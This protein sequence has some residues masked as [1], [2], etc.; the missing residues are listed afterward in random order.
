[1]KRSLHIM[2]IWGVIPLCI[3]LSAVYFFWDARALGAYGDDSPGYM[4]LAGRLLHHEP[5][6]FVGELSEEALAFFGD[7]KLARWTIPTHHQFINPSGMAASKYPL[8]L[9]LLLYIGARIVDAPEGMSSVQPLSGIGIV[10]GVYVLCMLIFRAERYRLAIALFSAT[11]LTTAPLFFQS[12]LS[13]PMRELPALAALIWA[14]IVALLALRSPSRTWSICGYLFAGILFGAGVAIRETLILIAPAL[15]VLVWSVV[16]QNRERMIAI[17]VGAC[18]LCIALVPLV[19]TSMTISEEKVPFKKRDTD[20][21]VILP[22]EGHLETIGLEN[23]FNNQGKYKIG[24]GSLPTYI[25]RM[26]T[27]LP[28][29][30]FGFFVLY[31]CVALYRKH[32]RTLAFLLLWALPILGI[33]ALWINPYARYIIPLYPVLVVLC[34]YGVVHLITIDFPRWYSQRAAIALACIFSVGMIAYVVPVFQH[35]LLERAP[36]QRTDREFIRADIE[37]MQVL[38]E[39]VQNVQRSSEKPLIVIITGKKQAGLSES[40]EV[41][42]GVSV[43]RFPIDQ[44]WTDTVE[45][46]QQFFAEQVFPRYTV[47]AL[48]DDSTSAEWYAWSSPYTIHREAEIPFTFQTRTQL[49]RIT[50]S[51]Y[52]T[53][54]IAP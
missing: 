46:T 45:R 48:V 47:V 17:V 50:P 29:A 26:H 20:A 14:Y 15:V 6:M 25:Y 18:G 49:V 35:M 38:A 43:V 7:E 3:V 34:A 44:R 22:N 28:V 12:V 4:Y 41:Y 53:P 24:E 52:A 42:T 32:R 54:S 5:L 21:V 36:E 37:A 2:L 40:I 39:A 10:F 51:E 11:A 19:Y 23:L 31:G 16:E 9:S 8:M 33:Y 1:M 30:G 27:A 13:Q